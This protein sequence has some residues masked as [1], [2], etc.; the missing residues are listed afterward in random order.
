MTLKDLGDD[1]LFQT[2]D[3]ILEA[4]EKFKQESNVALTDLSLQLSLLVE[5]TRHQ[6]IVCILKGLDF[7]TRQSRE[8][9]IPEAEYRTFEWIFRDD[10]GSTKQHVGF[11]QWLL[12]GNGNFWISGKAGSGKS[13]LM[14]Y[15]ARAQD[16]Q[17]FLQYWAGTARLIVAK[18]FF[19]EWWSANAK[20]TA[21][22]TANPSP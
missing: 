6:K 10:H 1:K 9:D 15:I 5:A 22:V 11:R 17:D 20:V 16:T 4:I 3:R 18:Y 7:E 2:K 12:T 8:S 13:V 19:L 14:N 21:G